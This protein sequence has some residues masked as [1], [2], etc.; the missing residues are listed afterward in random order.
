M[1]LKQNKEHQ[2]ICSNCSLSNPT[3]AENAREEI[4]RKNN[5]GG[6]QTNP[7]SRSIASPSLSR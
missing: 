6:Q 7:R 5:E 3:K 1:Q 4:E 2:E